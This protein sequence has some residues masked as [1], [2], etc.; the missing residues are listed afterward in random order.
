MPNMIKDIITLLGAGYSIDEM[1]T[2]DADTRSNTAALVGAGLNK[3]DAAAA[4]ELLAPEPVQQTTEKQPDSQTSPSDQTPEP[5]YRKLYEESQS[6]LQEAYRQAARE[7]AGE[8]QPPRT[9]DDVLADMVK[10]YII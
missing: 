2:M 7:P 6:K 10:Q 8:T 4:I 1:R 3:A 5:D 9:A